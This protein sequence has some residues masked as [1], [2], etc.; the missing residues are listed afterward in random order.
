[1]ATFS[2]QAILAWDGDVLRGAGAVTVGSGA[3]V[4]AATF[5]HI[6]GE[7]AGTTTPEELLAA[8]H[9]VCFGIAL[10]A[11][12]AQRGGSAEHVRATA[13]ITAEKGGAATQ[14]IR[15]RSS[16]LTAVVEGLAGVGP[17]ALPEIA[18]A[19]ED[20]CTISAAIRATVAISVEISGATFV[21]RQ[22]RSDY[23]ALSASVG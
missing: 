13:T 4:A 6:A 15:V 23:S 3:F 20:A 14:G 16:H 17:D 7:P 21:G 12:L 1:V 8:A 22:S 18:R 19:A 9:A 11:V 2:R 5:P 10:R